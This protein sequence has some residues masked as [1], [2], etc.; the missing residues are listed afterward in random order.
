MQFWCITLL[1]LKLEEGTI[2]QL[3]QH[4]P[5]LRNTTLRRTTLATSKLVTTLD[6]QASALHAAGCSD[7]PARLCRQQ[8]VCVIV[9]AVS[10]DRSVG[11][12]DSVSVWLHF[13]NSYTS[14][15]AAAERPAAIVRSC[16]CFDDHSCELISRESHVPTSR[17]TVAT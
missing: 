14:I 7:V 1:Q 11:C 17:K 4:S 2:N 5:A 6:K 9:P 16:A 8:I 3:R 15:L 13:A 10:A 12:R